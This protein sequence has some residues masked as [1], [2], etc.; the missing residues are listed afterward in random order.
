MPKLNR[1]LI[2]SWLEAH[3]WTVHRLT[4]ECNA[5]GEDNFAEGT[6]RNAVNGIDPI[7]PGRVHV[8]CKVT[9]KYGDGLSYTD[10]VAT[11]TNE[12]A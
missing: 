8:I 1:A 6:L 11:P 9:A 10:L 5:L 4:V 3:N 2:R 12:R 7:R